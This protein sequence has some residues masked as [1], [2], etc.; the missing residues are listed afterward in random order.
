MRIM[1]NLSLQKMKDGN[2]KLM[3]H[4]S[5][6]R[7]RMVE[8]YH[9]E[10]HHNY[11]EFE[12]QHVRYALAAG[13]N[14]EDADMQNIFLEA[15]NIVDVANNTY[16]NYK[17]QIDVHAN[18]ADER[19]KEEDRV[20]DK[21]RKLV[22]FEAEKNGVML[23]LA[24]HQDQ[25]RSGGQPSPEALQDELRYLEEKFKVVLQLVEDIL[26][27]ANE[28]EEERFIIAKTEIEVKYRK[29]V[30]EITCF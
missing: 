17:E 9:N 3:E 14:L 8:R 18:A 30:F 24:D 16:S 25:I 27:V 23:S 6:K 10:I 21:K 26:E 5:A 11:T 29:S 4:V 1:R 12:N 28:E 22:K 2:K 7:G 15:S 20:R 13:K 19:R